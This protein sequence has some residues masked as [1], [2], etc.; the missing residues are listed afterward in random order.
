MSVLL[1]GSAFLGGLAVILGAFGAHALKNQLTIDQLTSFQTGIRYQFYHVFAIFLCV[2]IGERFNINLSYAGYCFLIGIL[3][4][5][6]S[7]YLLSCKELLGIESFSKLL[8]PITPLGGLFFII[9][10]AIMAIQFIKAN[11][12]N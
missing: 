8:G 1:T 11:Q 2:I 9:G 4:F 6:G 7:I 12:L 5:S 10:W 3:L